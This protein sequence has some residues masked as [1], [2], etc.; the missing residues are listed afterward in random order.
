MASMYCGNTCV[1][2]VPRFSTTPCTPH[3]ADLRP[4]P[5]TPYRTEHMP[6]LNAVP[7]YARSVPGTG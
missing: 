7:R 2:P 6:V 1:H 4:L 5:H 3:T